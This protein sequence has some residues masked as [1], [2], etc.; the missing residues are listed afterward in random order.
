M[1]SDSPAIEIQVNGETQQIAADLTV[2]EFLS[3][4]DLTAERLAI[5]YNLDILPRSAWT[6]TK[7]RAGDKLEIVHF[8]GGG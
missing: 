2:T 4:L 8:V 3:T 6:E 7:L 1:P 5:E